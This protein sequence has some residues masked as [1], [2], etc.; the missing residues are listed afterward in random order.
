MPM[1]GPVLATARLLLRDLEPGDVDALAEILGDPE[2]MRFY[3]AP[4]SRSESLGWIEWC[5]RSYEENGFGLWALVLKGIGEF[6]GDCG[7]TVQHVDGERFVEAGWHVKRSRW[8]KGLASEACLA[9]RDHA[10]RVVGVDRVISL[11][12]VENEP[13]AGV[14]RKLGMRVWRHTEHAGFDHFVFSID[15]TEWQ[16][17]AERHDEPSRRV[18]P[19]AGRL[20]S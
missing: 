17:L 3:P 13:S 6:V 15:R 10:F 7:L 1:W 5:R 8:R 20:S 2:T 16:L 11:V 9:V 18:A 4:K 14:A 12:R 19:G